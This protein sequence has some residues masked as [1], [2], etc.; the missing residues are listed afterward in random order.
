MKQAEKIF[1]KL[2]AAYVSFSSVTD[3]NSAGLALLLEMARYMKLQNKP[4]YFQDLPKQINIVARAYGI[5]A[6]L[7][8]RLNSQDF[9]SV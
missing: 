6:E 9:Q 3:S 5:E 1:K 8:V 2:D 4:I 7:D